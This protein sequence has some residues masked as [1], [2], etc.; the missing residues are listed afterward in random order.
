MKKQWMWGLFSAVL[1]VVFACSLPMQGNAPSPS[2]AQTAAAQTVQAILVQQTQAAVTPSSGESA[3]ATPATPA[4]QA[5]PTT[6]ASP[7]PTATPQPSVP[8]PTSTPKPCN[9]AHF[10][11]DVT[12][13]DG[14][15]FL[16]N[17]ALTKTWRLQNVGTCTW[18]NYALV[19]DHGD[20][21]GGPS[22]VP[23]SGVVPPGQ[24]V[25]ISVNL[26][27]P[28]SPGTYRG[29]WRLRDDKGVV[30]GLV[31]GE[32]F[33]VDIK[34]V[35]ASP[36]PTST[37][38]VTPSPTA[39]PPAN[40]TVTLHTIASEDGH[41]LDSGSVG[42][43][44]WAGAYNN[45]RMDAFLS[46]NIS[47]IPAGAHIVSVSLDLSNATLEGDV[48]GILGWM[49]VYHDEYG[50]LDGSDFVPG[51]PTGAI[52][53]YASKPTG[54]FSSNGLL[55]AVQSRVGH[56]RVQFRYQF[57]NTSGTH[58]YFLSDAVLTIVYTNP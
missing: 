5:S 37:P 15:A 7:P 55:S 13:P 42:V 30:F 50:T 31:T 2:Q 26:T 16:P 1:L 57:Q 32:P 12:V 35:A 11:R 51:F 48:F 43:K 53:T 29:Y 6:M 20:A 17:Q 8:P 33:W 39:A 28:A 19:F 44:P 25:D 23:V 40:V 56:T 36:T 24:S 58:R 47:S 21:M 45:R 10:V 27:A 22:V 3:S 14:T 38:T 49:R 4:P 52:Y 46:F 34:V 18:Q 41:V 9:L 54:P